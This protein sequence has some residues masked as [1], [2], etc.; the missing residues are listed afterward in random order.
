MVTSG[1]ASHTDSD[2]GSGGFGL[3]SRLWDVQYARHSTRKSSRFKAA[4]GLRG[5]KVR[6]RDSQMPVEEAS[7]VM[8]SL[9]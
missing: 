9:D 7:A 8:G 3:P 6:A 5:F 4:P 2:S 1:E